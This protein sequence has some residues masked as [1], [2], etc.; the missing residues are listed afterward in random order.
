MAEDH[1]LV[2]SEQ[3]LMEFREVIKRKAPEH[4][5]TI[6]EHKKRRQTD[7]I[8]MSSF[9]HP[10]LKRI[11]STRKDYSGAFRCKTK[12]WVHREIWVHFLVHGSK[13][14]TPAQC[15]K[16][17]SKNSD[18]GIINRT[19]C[20]NDCI[21]FFLGSLAGFGKIVFMPELPCLLII[22]HPA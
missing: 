15:G 4:L 13:R 19:F 10:T 14:S 2:L 21:K 7:E 5:S 16:D 8:R 17:A 18:H 22:F 12:I 9:W 20:N 1:E 3:N 6:S 11:Q